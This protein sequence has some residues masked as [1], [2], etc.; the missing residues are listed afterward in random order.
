MVGGMEVR[1]AEHSVCRFGVSPH[2]EDAQKSGRDNPY[3]ASFVGG[4]LNG[5]LFRDDVGGESRDRTRV[6]GHVNDGS[7]R[8]RAGAPRTWLA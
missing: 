8:L 5:L 2:L 1:C 4:S 6:S 3:S 7:Y